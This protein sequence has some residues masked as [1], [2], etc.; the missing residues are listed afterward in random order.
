MIFM[1]YIMISEQDNASKNDSVGLCFWT[2]FQAVGIACVVTIIC[3]SILF[4]GGYFDASTKTD[5]TTITK[6]QYSNWHYSLTTVGFI[7]L[8]ANCKCLF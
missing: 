3:R 5:S 7:Y 6:A 1:L 2:L 4:N 8:Y